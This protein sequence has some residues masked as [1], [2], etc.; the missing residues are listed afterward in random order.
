MKKGTIYLR[1]FGKVSLQRFR[2]D[3]YKIVSFD[4]KQYKLWKLLIFLIYYRDKCYGRS[5]LYGMLWEEKMVENPS[6]SLKVLCHKLR[7][8]LKDSG[9]ISETEAAIL[10]EPGY[11]Y[12]WNHELPCLTDADIFKE[13]YFKLKNM[14]L[15]DVKEAQQY[16]ENIRILY[17]G[18]FLNELSKEVWVI[19]HQMSFQNLYIQSSLTYARLQMENKNYLKAIEVLQSVI[20]YDYYNETAY[21]LTIRAYVEQK[22]YGNAMKLYRHVKEMFKKDLG[23]L[24][25]CE[26]LE[27]MTENNDKEK[28]EP[29]LQK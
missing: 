25:V 3:G 13:N 14:E 11:G 26:E 19:P 29:A 15:P 24:F 8:F 4:K 17:R 1:V 6:N 7:N 23:V 10:S 27:C 21:L 16:Y 20:A 22:T 5:E 18:K 2:E 9:I 12:R 28:N